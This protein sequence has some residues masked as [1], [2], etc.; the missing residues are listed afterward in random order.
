MTEEMK[1]KPLKCYRR[2]EEG[3]NIHQNAIHRHSHF[4][5]VTSFGAAIATFLIR[6]LQKAVDKSCNGKEHGEDVKEHDQ[7]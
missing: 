1:N 3:V 6:K 7:K 4:V 5:Y 2:S